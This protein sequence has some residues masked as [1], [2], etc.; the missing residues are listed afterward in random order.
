MN[1]HFLSFQI[2]ACLLVTLA[3]ALFLLSGCTQTEITSVW[4]D[5]EYH[6]D[7]I[8]NVFV[9]GVAKN[10]GLRRIL[11]DEFVT[12]FKGRGVAATASYRV[13]PDEDLGNEKKLESQVKESGSDAILMTRVID[14]RRDSQYIPPDYIYA[15][16]I[17]YYGGWHGYYNQ[18]WM[19]T[20]GYTVE[21]ETAVLET[22]LYDLKTDKLIW[23][24]RSD[25]P[26]DGKMGKL[27]KDFA[28][29]I[30]NQLADAKLI[31]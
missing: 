27:I 7:G 10:G 1:R 13:L 3:V 28:R 12:L 21:Y 18:A 30:I 31:Q 16:P 8:N 24:A 22:N 6:G 17:N 15:P 11:E 19:L 20:P 29:L 4:V 5:P 2:M 26:T 23:S 25:T 14:I 9:V